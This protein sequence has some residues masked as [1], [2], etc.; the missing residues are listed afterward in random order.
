MCEVPRSPG[1]GRDDI[2]V[3]L[4]LKSISKCSDGTELE[5]AR[6]YRDLESKFAEAQR[7][8]RKRRVKSIRAKIADRRKD[9]LHKFSRAL[10]DRARTI[11]VG[12]VSASAMAKTR[13]IAKSV[14]DVGWSMLRGMLRH[15]CGHAGV[16]YAEV[17]EA[18]TTRTCSTC[19]CLS[20]PTGLAGL[21]VRRWR[22]SECGSEHDRDHNAARNIARLGCE[23][24]CPSRHGSPGL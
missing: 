21:G 20:G 18:H 11:T 6:F 14:L 9:S 1:H 22:C 7:K 5:P 17:D 13:R 8:K 15:K 12:D 4:G 23:T 24:P 19:G 10:V 2:G 16:A 3:D